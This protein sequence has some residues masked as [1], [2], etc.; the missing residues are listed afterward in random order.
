MKQNS[1]MILTDVIDFNDPF[2]IRSMFRLRDTKLL[3]N[4]YGSYL[5]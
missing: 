2:L 5:K 3:F 4:M 1:I